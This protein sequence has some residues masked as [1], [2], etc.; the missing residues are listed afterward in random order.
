MTKKLVRLKTHP[1]DGIPRKKPDIGCAVRYEIIN[2][3]MRKHGW[4]RK[5][6][7]KVQ[8]DVVEELPPMN[9]DTRNK[10]AVWLKTF[11]TGFPQ[12]WDA[13]DVVKLYLRYHG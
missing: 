8:I 3:F 11:S 9:K 5:K 2:N 12:V 6:K 4:I 7:K 13:A 10:L 1:F